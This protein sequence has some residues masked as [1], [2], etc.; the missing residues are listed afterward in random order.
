MLTGGAGA[1]IEAQRPCKHQPAGSPRSSSHHSP[2]ARPA[3]VLSMPTA[4]RVLDREASQARPA[5]SKCT[6]G[7][8]GRPA[9]VAATGFTCCT[10]SLAHKGMNAPADRKAGQLLL[11][12]AGLA[13]WMLEQQEGEGRPAG[14]PAI[15]IWICRQAGRW[16]GRRVGRQLARWAGSARSA[17]AEVVHSRRGGCSWG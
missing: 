13:F 5:L 7:S 12:E 17:Q 11:G 1:C 2:P 10:G 15:R 3:G 9:S 14:R 6:R 16:A 4:L 8:R